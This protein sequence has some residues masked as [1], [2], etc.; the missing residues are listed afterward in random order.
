[1]AL[2]LHKKHHVP[3]DFI[4]KVFSAMDGLVTPWGNNIKYT[5]CY[6]EPYSDVYAES[7]DLIK[8]LT[9]VD[10]DVVIQSIL[11]S[12]PSSVHDSKLKTRHCNVTKSEDIKY[13]NLCQDLETF[14]KSYASL[15]KILLLREKISPLDSL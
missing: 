13:I 8:L 1:M 10:N 5:K 7:D 14:E 12:K 4:K 3:D 2:L 6:Y 11:M 15:Y 9:F